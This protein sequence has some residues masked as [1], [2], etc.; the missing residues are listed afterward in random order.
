MNSETSLAVQS[1]TRADMRDRH[2]RLM[3]SN[4]RLRMRDAAAGLGVSEAELL[5]AYAGDTVTVL[6][7]DCEAILKRVMALGRVMAL[8]RN[9]YCVHERKGEYRSLSFG[10]GIGL[11]V[12]EDIDLRLF[13]SHWQHV[14]AVQEAKGGTVARS[15][16]F[17][18][19]RGDAIHKIHLLPESDADEFERLVKD[20]ESSDEPTLSF[21]DVI[22]EESRVRGLPQG[23]DANAFRAEWDALIDTHDFF[24]LLKRHGIHRLDAFEVAGAAR[25]LPIGLLAYREVLEAARDHELPIMVFVGNSGC[26]QIHTGPL[27]TLK[28][29]GPWFNVLD[30]D[31]N[32]HVLET[33]IEQAWLVRKPTRD[34]VV[35]SIELFDSGGQPVMMLFG[36]RKPGKPENLA[37]RRI[38][39][40]VID[41]V[42]A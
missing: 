4:G 36:A 8:T 31:F 7:R 10:N 35:T 15:L 3:E 26:I 12:G 27:R 19:A 18:D 41:R 38:A 5:S 22:N 32:L 30:P 6:R 28:E 23:F 17:F 33:G 1:A 20:F 14:F 40:A 16:Q 42:P 39:E 13:M 24:P 21:D 2:R 25:A 34:G 9:A 37:W 29:M 11:A